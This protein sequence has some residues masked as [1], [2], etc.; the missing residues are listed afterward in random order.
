MDT[1]V[2]IYIRFSITGDLHNVSRRPSITLQGDRVQLP[3]GTMTTVCGRLS[4]T[5]F[6]LHFKVFEQAFCLDK[7]SLFFMCNDVS[8]VIILAT[9]RYCVK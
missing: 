2:K 9:C 4:I 5:R 6:P 1:C 7:S 3:L 8:D